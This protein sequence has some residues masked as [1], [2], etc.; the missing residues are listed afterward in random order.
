M[1]CTLN[2]LSLLT[3]LP[4]QLIDESAHSSQSTRNAKLRTLSIKLCTVYD[5]LPRGIY[6]SGIHDVEAAPVSRYIFGEEYRA[7]LKG[8]DIMLRLP[9]VVPTNESDN[10]K[11]LLQVRLV[12][13]CISPSRS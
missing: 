9:R 8:Q 13:V 11:I 5:K 3:P 1:S 10:R 4:L 2:T 12:L 6:L 7:K